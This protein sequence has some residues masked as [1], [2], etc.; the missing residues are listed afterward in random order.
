MNNLRKSKRQSSKRQRGGKSSCTKAHGDMEKCHSMEGCV[1]SRSS[2]MVKGILGMCKKTKAKDVEAA[3]RKEEQKYM[4]LKS[5][6]TPARSAKKSVKKMRK[7]SS[8]KSCKHAHGDV[9][10]CHSIEGCVYSVANK[11]C[12]KTKAKDVA[13]ARERA[14]YRYALENAPGVTPR[15]SRGKSGKRHVPTASPSLYKGLLASQSKRSD[16]PSF[17][18]IAKRS[19]RR[20]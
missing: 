7:R 5:S 6:P 9:H 19:R 16:S 4:V 15:A 12:K 11:M 2:G 20:S 1:F 13:A 3:R 8:K 14:V 18:A 17:S 10:Y